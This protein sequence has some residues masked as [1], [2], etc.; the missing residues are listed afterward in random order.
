MKWYYVVAISLLAFLAGYQYALR[1][2][3]LERDEDGVILCQGGV[4]VGWQFK[5]L[6]ADPP[7]K[8]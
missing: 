8:A 4:C 7:L 1:G 5:Q 3:T 2:I 6:P